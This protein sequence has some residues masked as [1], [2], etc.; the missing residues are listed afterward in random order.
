MPLGLYRQGY[1]Q[2]CCT[3]HVPRR[4][5]P[6]Q[7]SR[8]QGVVPQHVALVIQHGDRGRLRRGLG[9]RAE[10]KRQR[11]PEG[12]KVRGV[13]TGWAKVLT[14]SFVMRRRAAVVR[15]ASPPSG[16]AYHRPDSVRTSPMSAA[17]DV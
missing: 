5:A 3:A 1:I 8:Y 2:L 7:V 13:R 17:A 14:T 9:R 4:Q 6:H 12:Q 16:E 11:G 15:R 10:G